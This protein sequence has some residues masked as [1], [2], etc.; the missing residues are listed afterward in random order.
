MI[1]PQLKIHNIAKLS[2]LQNLNITLFSGA[3]NINIACSISTCKQE[4]PCARKVPTAMQHYI[5]CLYPRKCLF[6]S[7]VKAS[8]PPMQSDVG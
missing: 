5:I 1:T 2:I 3:D 6:K 4:A 7:L 8:E